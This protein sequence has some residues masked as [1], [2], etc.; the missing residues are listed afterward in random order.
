MS[1][2]YHKKLNAELTILITNL[3]NSY[4]NITQNDKRFTQYLSY[5]KN[6][7]NDKS[8]LYVPRPK[9]VEA[10]IESLTEK[11]DINSQFDKSKLLNDYINR[12]KTIF[13]N[14]S[15][16]KKE[17]LFSYIYLIL[18]LSHSPLNTVV[19]LDMMREKFENRYIKNKYDQYIK[20]ANYV[21]EEVGKIE[22]E[23]TFEFEKVDYDEKTPSWSEEEDGANVK[24]E[25]KNNEIKNED[26][27]KIEE[28]LQKL[29]KELTMKKALMIRKKK[30][31]LLD[32]EKKKKIIFNSFTSLFTNNDYY[33]NMKYCF[34]EHLLNMNLRTMK[35]NSITSPLYVD[36]DFILNR[37]LHQF[38]LFTNED[39]NNENAFID[40]FSSIAPIE[41]SK[42]LMMNI[43]Q[44]LN[45]KRHDLNFLR[46]IEVIFGHHEISS[47][48]FD[49]FK[50]II[51]EIIIFHDI[52]IDQLLKLLYYQKGKIE[53]FEIEKKIFGDNFMNNSNFDFIS[54]FFQKIK[55]IIV[56][57]LEKK[58]KFTIMKFINFY[59]KFLT[60][61][62]DFCLLL[63]KKIISTK[64]KL[65][66]LN[67]FSNSILIKF[68]IDDLYNLTKNHVDF[69][70]E[71]FISIIDTYSK[72]IYEFILNGN[73]IDVNNEFFI[74]HLLARRDKKKIIFCFNEK[75]QIFNWVDCFKIKSFCIGKDNEG[76]C[77][78]LAFMIGDVHFKILETA[79]TTF[80]MKNLNV[81]NYFE[82]LNRNLLYGSTEREKEKIPNEIVKTEEK[83]I[84][85]EEDFNELKKLN[86]SLKIKKEDIIK[87]GN[88]IGNLE[89]TKD[90]EVNKININS[91]QTLINQPK[92]IKEPKKEDN[93]N[94]ILPNSHNTTSITSNEILNFSNNISPEQQNNFLP[95]LD[96]EMTDLTTP[97]RAHNMN[98]I[99]TIN[100][101]SFNPELSQI[102]NLFPKGKNNKT[103]YNINIILSNLFLNRILQINSIIN[104]KFL[105]V[106]ISKLNIEKHFDLMFNLYLFKAGFS[107][108]KFIH[109][110]NSFIFTSSKVSTLITTERS[111]FL[112]SLLTELSHSPSSDLSS[113]SSLIDSNVS[114][115]FNDIQ[116]LVFHTR[117]DLIKMNY[118][119]P[120]PISIFFDKAIIANYN[121]VFNFIVKIKRTFSMI[122]DITLDKKLK[123]CYL[124]NE[125]NKKAKI[126]AKSLIEYRLFIM[127]FAYEIEFFIFHFVIEKFISKFKKKIQ[128][129]NSI[130]QFINTHS[131]FI[132]DIITFLGMGEEKNMKKI[133]KLL[134]LVIAYKTLVDKFELCDRSNE[135][136]IDEAYM[137]VVNAMGKYSKREGKIKEMIENLKEKLSQ[138]IK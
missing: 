109:S 71:I 81:I 29:Q 69:H 117:E 113:F 89:F 97:L 73:L 22:I 21:D 83:K 127:D 78:P 111:F 76:A 50:F 66:S 88:E 47:V 59:N 130:D 94:I 137:E 114:I 14:K 72:F 128:T 118:S 15:L 3:L 80:L 37:I 36:N 27:E 54:N 25:E 10:K 67:K 5:I 92:P 75:F 9:D 38:S 102:T 7:L 120:L 121:L 103:Q 84:E 64:N 52:I 106:L 23:K 18:Q 138:Q 87:L 34:Y 93:N 90:E 125:A 68:F 60:P 63:S 135:K 31:S 46:Q 6:Y 55:K 30:E 53:N 100:P 39:I 123:Q 44:K 77:V 45:G 86:E 115:S 126:I 65:I 20:S 56:K 105:D 61:L 136:E 112:K 43:L 107:M 26:K 2:D 8:L 99:S 134:N 40:K 95:L 124:T 57:I 79:K 91:F 132:R 32:D 101:S 108:N 17:N 122:R 58:E 129:L 48:I 85:N 49:K 28:K 104:R 74:D 1:S 41:M 51:N 33:S 62:I 12:L 16:I 119:P 133:Y 131:R 4:L 98:E 13:E 116:S 35:N 11:L 82:D 24:E 70:I 110:L 19:N 42:E 96:V